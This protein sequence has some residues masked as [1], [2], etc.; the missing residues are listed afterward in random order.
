MRELGRKRERDR[1]KK[2]DE[3]KERDGEVLQ[4]NKEF[5]GILHCILLNYMNPI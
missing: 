3:E 5:I 4:R 1:E 2:R